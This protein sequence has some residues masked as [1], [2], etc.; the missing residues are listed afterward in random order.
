MKNK[1]I[2]SVILVAGLLFAGSSG[3]TVYSQTPQNTPAKQKTMQYTCPMHTEVVSDKPGNCPKCGMTMVE[4]KDM[5]M[6][7]NMHQMQDSTTTKKEGMKTDSTTMKKDMMK[8]KSD[9]TTLKKGP[10][11]K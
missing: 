10:I 2:Y 8:M 11:Y 5:K 7:D 6:N 1:F 3:N 4:K 9:S